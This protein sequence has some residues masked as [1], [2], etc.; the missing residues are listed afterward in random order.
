MLLNS[1][2]ITMPRLFYLMPGRGKAGGMRDYPLE[3]G[4]GMCFCFNKFIAET[5][6][7]SHSFLC[8]PLKSRAVAF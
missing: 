1:R 3:I 2:G 7:C 4:G 5:H 6:P 8:A